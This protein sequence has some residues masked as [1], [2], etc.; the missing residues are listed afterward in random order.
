[1]LSGDGKSGLVFSVFPHKKIPRPKDFIRQKL[2]KTE[3]KNF[4]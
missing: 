4:W 3:T 1:M 2:Y